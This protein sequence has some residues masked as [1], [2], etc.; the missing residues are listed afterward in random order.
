MFAIP[1]ATITRK[2]VAGKSG[3]GFVVSERALG[4]IQRMG[5]QAAG[6]MTAFAVP[7]LYH[8]TKNA[9]QADSS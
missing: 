6:Q 3:V 9:F 1:T 8:A 4:S 2:E 5:V 7:S